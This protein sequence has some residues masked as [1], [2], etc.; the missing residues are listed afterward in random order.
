MSKTVELKELQNVI[1]EVIEKDGE[2]SFV[3]AGISMWPMLRNRKDKIFLVKSDG[4]L[5]TGDIP[6]FKTD[7]GKFILHRIIGSD[8]NGYITRGDNRW[9]SEY[10]IK[11]KNII[12]VLKAFERN[13]KIYTVDCFKYKC[14]V[15]CIPLIRFLHKAYRYLKYHLI[16]K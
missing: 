1:E 8:R 16:K 2:V 4:R 6:F 11:E 3:S 7:S 5:K 12:A 14:Y 9:D 13:G 10:G 15:K